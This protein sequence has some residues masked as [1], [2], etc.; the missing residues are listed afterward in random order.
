[1][2]FLVA[3]LIALGAWLAYRTWSRRQTRARLLATPLTDGQREIVLARVPL[4]RRLPAEL[5]AG[6]EGKINAFLGQIEFIGCDG[7]V[8]T[9]EMRLSIAAQACLLVVNT[10]TWYRDLRTVLVYPGAFKS[11]RLERDGYVVTERESVRIGESWARGPVVL[12]WPHSVEGG[13]DDRDGHNVVFHEFAHQIDSQSGHADGAPVLHRGQS[14]ATWER[15]FVAA[16][17]RHVERVGHGGRTVLDS[18]GAASLEEFFAVAIE[19]FLEKPAA[20]REAEPDVYAQLEELL[21][22]DPVRW[23]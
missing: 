15:V 1:M 13:R 9:E 23:E 2:Q 21:Q 18:Y 14:Y 17:R 8:V 3:A 11:R 19:A 6:L 10:E 20:L 16:Y 4:V 5:R 22:L 7:L 12:S